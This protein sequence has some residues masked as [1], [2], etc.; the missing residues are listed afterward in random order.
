MTD[1]IC[2]DVFPGYRE[3]LTLGVNKP[4]SVAGGAGRRDQLCTLG[5]RGLSGPRSLQSMK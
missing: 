2:I 1:H 3:A 5:G 4:S